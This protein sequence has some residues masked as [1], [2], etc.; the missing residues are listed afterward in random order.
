M[1]PNHGI[2]IIDPGL[3][4]QPMY[5][6]IPKK[7]K[8]KEMALKYA[9]FL[10]SPKIQAEVIVEK[11]TWYPGID[12]K[13]VIPHV[14]EEGQNK[15]FKDISAEDLEKRVLSFPIVEFFDNMKEAYERY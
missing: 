7:A 1:N 5:V 10:T 11:F 8:N 6:V 12:A 13:A 14:S 3:P 15:L 2:K 9:D 4:G